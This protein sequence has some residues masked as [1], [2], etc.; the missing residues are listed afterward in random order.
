MT[1]TGGDVYQFSFEPRDYLSSFCSFG[2]GRD[3]IL[4]FRLQKCFEAFKSGD[5]GGDV[6]IDIG[7]GPS[8]YQLLSACQAFKSIIATDFTDKN[9]QELEKWLK[10]E[11]GAYDWSDF[12]K[13]VCELEGDREKWREKEEKLR[14]TIKH[15]LRCDVTKSNPLDPLV[16]SPADGLISTLCLE[17]A[18]KDINSYRSA[19]RNI[20]SLLKP[21]G[22]LVLIGVLGDSFYKVGQQTFFCLPLDAQTVRGAVEDAGYTIKEMDVFLIPDVASHLDI[23]DS[24]GNFFLVARKEAKD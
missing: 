16:I 14:S 7:T 1:F 18:C 19:L 3:D 9:R 8:I 5:I 4:N 6:L 12:S 13:V 22:H 10:R 17:T 11:P 24:Y 20:T 21:G 15:V 23:T 2:K